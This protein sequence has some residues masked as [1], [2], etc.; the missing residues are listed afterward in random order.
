V[1]ENRD[2]LDRIAEALIEKEAIE[3]AEIEELVAGVQGARQKEA[4]LEPIDSLPS[5]DSPE[6][7]F[8]DEELV[9]DGAE[10]MAS[11]RAHRDS[12]APPVR[13]SVP[14]PP[15]GKVPAPVRAAQR[16]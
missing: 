14:P 6:L 7:A 8:D 15:N 4:T 12:V 13:D 11:P 16:D 9:G 3:R 10:S 5:I 2:L 1:S